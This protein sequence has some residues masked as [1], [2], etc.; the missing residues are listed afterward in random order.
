MHLPESLTKEARVDDIEFKIFDFKSIIESLFSPVGF[1][2]FS[3]FLAIFGQQ[4]FSSIYGLY[5]L[6]KFGYGPEEVGT[7]LMGMAF[8]YTLSQGVLVGPLTKKL[9]DYNLIKIS[10][11][12]SA[13]GFLLIILASNYISLFITMSIFILFNSFIK[14]TAISIVSKSANQEEQGKAM[15][16]VESYMSLGRIFGPIW[17]GIIFDV[18]L[19]FPFIS[20]IIVFMSICTF[21]VLKKDSL[22]QIQEF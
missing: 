2:L 16:I 3:A 7:L 9:G 6:E 1:G 14:P 4:I 20:G 21:Q 10:F 8:M 12:G 5:T 19:Y 15:G 11:F 18:N 13:I 17:G 22:K